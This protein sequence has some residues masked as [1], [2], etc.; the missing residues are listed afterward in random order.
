MT[1]YYVDPLAAGSNDGTSW[2]NA[3]TSIQSAFDTAVVGD[4]VYCRGTQTV[5]A[6]IDVDTNSG[7]NAGGFIKFVG[8][9]ASGTVDGTRFTIQGD[10]AN[11]CD[12]LYKT[13]A[14]SMRHHNHRR[15]RTQYGLASTGREGR[16]ADVP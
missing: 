7:T 16:R 15:A 5:A 6:R 12:L 2:T 4:I 3:W 8:C 13:G 1:T 9:N 14:M 10:G 11:A